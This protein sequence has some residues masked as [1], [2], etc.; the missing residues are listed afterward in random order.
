MVKGMLLIGMGDEWWWRWRGV[1]VM[2]M[3]MGDD[4]IQVGEGFVMNS[5]ERNG[6]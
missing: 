5:D 6:K 4:G 3:V 1:M 2:V